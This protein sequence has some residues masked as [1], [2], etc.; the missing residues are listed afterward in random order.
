MQA[1]EQLNK[2]SKNNRDIK[3]YLRQ[4]SISAVLL[5][6][7]V[8]CLPKSQQ[9]GNWGESSRWVSDIHFLLLTEV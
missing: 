9:H 6:G 1:T 4:D 3:R 7:A 8:F 5:D 2:V